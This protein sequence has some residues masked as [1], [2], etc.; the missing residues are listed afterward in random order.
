VRLND[1][2]DLAFIKNTVNTTSDGIVAYTRA[3]DCY[4]ADNTVTGAT[5]WNVGAL[6]VNG[7]NVGEGI[8]VTG[9]GHV[10]EHNRVKGFRDGISL[11]E[12][13]EADDQFSIDIVENDISE[14]ADDGVE[15]DFCFHNCRTVRNRF[16]NVFMAMSS[17]P[18]LGG[19]TYFIR[20]AAYNVILSAFKLQRSSVGDVVLHNTVVK[21]GDAFA[22][23]TDEPI[24]RA[25][26]RNN[27]MIGGPGGTYNGY[28]NG[29]GRVMDLVPIQPS[30]DLDFDA[31]GSTTGM[32]TGKLGAVRFNSLAELKAMTKE[33]HARAVDL[34]VFAATVTV[35]SSPFPALP[36]ADLRPKPGGAAID[37]AEVISNVSDVFAGGAPDVGA[38]E[39]GASL[40][41]YG[42]R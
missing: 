40:P 33:M 39:A 11:L 32:F 1:G 36:V 16:T 12:E 37:A 10:I 8:L 7:A 30:C 23:Y 25:L 3:E 35:P 31:L 34:S 5:Q 2:R 14:C 29:S 18:S 42:P 22:I 28:S 20:N 41:R 21:N 38:Y 27:L 6:G 26:F 19:P 15:S 9:P 24:E 13:G 17:Q 4:F